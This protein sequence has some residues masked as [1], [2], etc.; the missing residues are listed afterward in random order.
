MARRPIER[1]SKKLHYQ[2]ASEE[3]GEGADKGRLQRCGG[4]LMAEKDLSHVRSPVFRVAE[5]GGPS[6]G[7][8]AVHLHKPK[9]IFQIMETQPPA[10]LRIFRSGSQGSAKWSALTATGRGGMKTDRL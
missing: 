2:V 4:K 5:V 8:Q 6:G 9:S 1:L 10:L 7:R 3:G